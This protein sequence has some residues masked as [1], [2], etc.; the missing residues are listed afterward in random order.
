[1]D[2]LLFYRNELLTEEKYKIVFVD[3]SGWNLSSIT[4]YVE[5]N[6]S[7]EFLSLNPADFDVTKGKGY[8]ELLLINKAI[9]NSVF[10]K[11]A[12]GFVK[13]TGR[14]Q[15]TILNILSIMQVDFLNEKVI[16]I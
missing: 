11:E 3:N 4:S 10:I 15:Y 1:M 13:V 16:C 6:P 5:G 9:E 2:T 7:I 14:Y 12:G 8:N